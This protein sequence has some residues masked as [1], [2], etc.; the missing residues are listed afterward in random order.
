MFPDANPPTPKEVNGYSDREKSR[1]FRLFG[2]FLDDPD[3]VSYDIDLFAATV[4]IDDLSEISKIFV[5]ADRFIETSDTLTQQ[6]GWSI[7]CRDPI[8][9][10]VPQI[11]KENLCRSLSKSFGVFIFGHDDQR[12]VSAKPHHLSVSY[13]QTALQEARISCV[14]IYQHGMKEPV[15]NFQSGNGNGSLIP[16][17]QRGWEVLLDIGITVKTP[18]KIPLF[19]S[20]DRRGYSGKFFKYDHNRGETYPM[21][22]FLGMEQRSTGDP[23]IFGSVRRPIYND[24]AGSEAFV[25]IYPNLVHGVKGLMKNILKTEPQTVRVLRDRLVEL[26]KL[27]DRLRSASEQ[28]SGLRLEVRIT[29]ASYSNIV[30]LHL[31]PWLNPKILLR[32]VELYNME[33]LRLV[34]VTQYLEQLDW[35]E[36]QIKGTCV[37][38]DSKRISFRAQKYYFELLTFFGGNFN[39][40]ILRK[41]LSM[42]FW[43][44]T[45]PKNL[46]EEPTAEDMETMESLTAPNADVIDL[47]KLAE[48]AETVRLYNWFG[49]Q[50]FAYKLKDRR[51]RG[52]KG[53]FDTPEELHKMILHLYPDNWQTK[54]ELR[55]I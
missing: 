24:V 14:R 15:E 49:A 32:H 33:N 47:Q 10:F 36:D 26:W 13:I 31:V 4:D 30:D 55:R 7:L 18:G 8:F 42:E 2:R 20:P 37:G 27:K 28:L 43:G 34:S 53:P 9:V 35:V 40:R 16:V 45:E 25:R 22:G 39:Q 41:G 29:G 38:R 23:Q 52:L 51:N 12:V 19:S 3:S 17:L 21:L 11:K 54:V 5:L 1:D 50:K 44:S 46:E 6:T 48:I